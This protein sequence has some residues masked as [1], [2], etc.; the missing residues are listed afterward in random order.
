L[1]S[2]TGSKWGSL[3]IDIRSKEDNE[4]VFKGVICSANDGYRA[5]SLFDF[6]N[7]SPLGFMIDK[8]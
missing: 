2:K 1:G 3:I 8:L 6:K 7:A 5:T 4:F